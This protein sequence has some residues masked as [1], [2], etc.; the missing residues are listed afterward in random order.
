MYFHGFLEKDWFEMHYTK[1]LWLWGGASTL[2]WCVRGVGEL[3]AP[4]KSLSLLLENAQ[5]PH[6]GPLRVAFNLLT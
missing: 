2:S 4:P 3:G 6:A 1:T 5:F